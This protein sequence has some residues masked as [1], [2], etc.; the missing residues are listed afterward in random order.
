MKSKTSPKVSALIIVVSTLLA[1]LLYSLTRNTAVEIRGNAAFGGEICFFLLPFIA[2]VFYKN[3][4]D[5]RK[6]RRNFVRNDR[7]Y[8]RIAESK[9]RYGYETVF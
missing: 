2:W 6:T 5:S 4:V 3:I 7:K 1:F 8:A 9:E